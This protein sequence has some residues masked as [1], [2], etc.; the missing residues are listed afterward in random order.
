M[1]EPSQSK[2]IQIPEGYSGGQRKQIGEDIVRFIKRRTQSGIDING[3]LF[4]GYSRFY[5]KSGTVDLTVTEQMLNSLELL[6]HGPGYVRIGFS[7]SRANDKARWSQSPY[8]EAAG[9]RPAR[10]FV[11]ISQSDLNLILEKYPL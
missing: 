11:G 5:D 7:N 2:I 4:E 6:S 9:K 10:E 8:G 3:N 1:A